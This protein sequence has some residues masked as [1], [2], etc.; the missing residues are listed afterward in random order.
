MLQESPPS[1]I[2]ISKI[3]QKGQA[4]IPLKIREILHLDLGDYISFAQQGDNIILKRAKKE[5][6][7]ILK[8]MENS[9]TEWN[10]AEDD[11]QFQYLNS[12]V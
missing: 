7:D 5:D 1:M 8:L 3:T 11:K 10:S 4:T 9:L 6:K 12:L 2:S